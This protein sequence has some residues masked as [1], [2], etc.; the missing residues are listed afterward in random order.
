MASP[1]SRTE[2]SRGAVARLAAAVASGLQMTEGATTLELG[3]SFRV[4]PDS[5]LFTEVRSLLGEQ[6]VV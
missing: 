6:A 2:E 4:K 5:D 1:G 3:P